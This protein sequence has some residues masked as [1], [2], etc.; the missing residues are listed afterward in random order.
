VNELCRDASVSTQTFEAAR[1]LLGETGVVELAV[2]VG[3]YTMLSY[4]MGAV[5]AC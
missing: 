1:E 3:Y 5:D 4:A 2:T